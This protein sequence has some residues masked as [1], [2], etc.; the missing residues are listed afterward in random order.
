MHAGVEWGESEQDCSQPQCSSVQHG[1]INNSSSC[2]VNDNASACA[3]G[4]SWPAL[5]TNPHSTLPNLLHFRTQA[6]QIGTA[7]SQHYYQTFS[8]NRAGL[9][10]L[11]QQ[12]SH[13]KFESKVAQGQQA[14]QQALNDLPKM[15][16]APKSLDAQPS[17]GGILVLISGD[18][19]MEGQSNAI[20]FS[21]VVHLIPTDA[22]MSNF[23]IHND[24]FK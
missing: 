9:S 24:I 16:L 11:Y 13:F 2:C 15:Q 22:Q 8:S 23:W 14:I 17:G 21:H 6:E 20:K 7:F 1:A 3:A 5:D 18:C 19:T 12:P 10:S 4:H